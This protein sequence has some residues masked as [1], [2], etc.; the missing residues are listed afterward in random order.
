MTAH[1]VI[2]TATGRIVLMC[3]VIALALFLHRQ[4]YDVA[5]ALLLAAAA[6]GI[7]GQVARR[8]LPRDTR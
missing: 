1:F 5:T 7:A 4:G 6:L 8:A 3:T 2:D